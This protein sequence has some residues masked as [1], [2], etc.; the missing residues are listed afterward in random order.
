MSLFNYF[1]RV[2]KAEKKADSPTEEKKAVADAMLSAPTTPK[3]TSGYVPFFFF[4]SPSLLLFIYLLSGSL[5][6]FLPVL[7]DFLFIS[8][9]FPLPCNLSAYSHTRFVNIFPHNL[10]WNQE[11]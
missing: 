7:E 3:K 4:S 2:P 6:V 11:K 10:Q 1:K 8:P 9:I 5:V